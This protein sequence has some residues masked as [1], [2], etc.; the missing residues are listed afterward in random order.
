[1]LG[2]LSLRARLLLAVIVL[3]A[4]GLVAADVATYSSLRSFLAHRTDNSLETPPT[5]RSRA[6]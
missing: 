6:R 5:A 4:V 2:R 3:A 1:M